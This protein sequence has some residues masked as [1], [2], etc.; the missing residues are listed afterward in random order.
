MRKERL[1]NEKTF[2]SFS[3]CSHALPTPHD[4]L[5]SIKKKLKSLGKHLPSKNSHLT[6]IYQSICNQLKI[7]WFPY[8][9]SPQCKVF[10]KRH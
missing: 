6:K 9:T 10:P 1:K 2:L 3:N 7:D 5:R 4:C 8:E